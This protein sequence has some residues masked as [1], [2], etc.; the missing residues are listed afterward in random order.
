MWGPPARTIFCVREP[1]GYLA[2]AVKKFPDV[3]L[4]AFRDEYVADIAAFEVIGGE[5]FVYHPGLTTEDYRR[6]LAPLEIPGGP[7][8]EFTY[9]G[10]TADHLVT[11]DMV[12]AYERVAAPSRQRQGA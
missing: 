12:Q 3:D 6:F 7:E 5:P 9:R 4:Q 2:S 1:S 8:H 11:D 10:E